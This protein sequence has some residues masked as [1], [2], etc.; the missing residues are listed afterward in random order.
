MFKKSRFATIALMVAALSACS[1]CAP[2][3]DPVQPK[4]LSS[5]EIQHQK[6]GERMKAR[7]ALKA[8]QEKGV[9]SAAGSSAPVN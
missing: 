5:W 2:E 3:P 8:E 6:N 9:A 4:K 1:V 7:A